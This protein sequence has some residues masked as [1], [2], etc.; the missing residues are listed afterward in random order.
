MKSG[1]T[2]VELLVTISIFIV[3]TSVAVFSNSAF[4]SSILLTDLGYQIALSVRQA[5]VYG[6]T[7]KAPQSCTTSSCPASNT[8]F[9]SGYGAH[10]DITIPAQYILFEDTANPTPNHTYD[11]SSE[12]LATYSIGRGYTLKRLCVL[13]S[14]VYKAVKTL[15]IS[16]IRPEPE[17]W[18]RAVDASSNVYGPGLLEADI[19]VQDPND[20][21]DRVIIIYPTGQ[22]SI[23]N[24]DANLCH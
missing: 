10:F 23:Q 1:F 4:N 17:S 8:G 5:Q 18:V 14:G 21:A 11:G 19:Y 2:L 13:T 3:I 6:I 7:V 22:I 24:S 20:I 9:N 15:D 16:F 12:T